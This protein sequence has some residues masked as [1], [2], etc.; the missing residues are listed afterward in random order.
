[1]ESTIQRILRQDRNQ[2]KFKLVCLPKNA[3]GHFNA[4]YMQNSNT[5]LD[6]NQAWPH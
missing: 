6:S 3:P 4:G 5:D 1:M 2:S